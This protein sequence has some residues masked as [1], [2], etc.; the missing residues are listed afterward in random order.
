MSETVDVANI[1][2]KARGRA[3][4]VSP[5]NISVLKIETPEGSGLLYEARNGNLEIITRP[6][7]PSPPPPP[8]P[9]PSSELGGGV[10]VGDGGVDGRV[11]I[12]LP[13]LAS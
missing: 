6:A 2:L 10:L 7:P 13:F 4:S 3:G 5:L 11:M 8:E 1:L 9:P 12:K